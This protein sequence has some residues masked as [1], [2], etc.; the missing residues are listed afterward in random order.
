MAA[1]G[2]ILIKVTGASTGV[3]NINTE[4]AWFSDDN[5]TESFYSLL[6]GDGGWRV[7]RF[8]SSTSFALLVEVGEV[9]KGGNGGWLL[10]GWLVG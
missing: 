1:A 3:I 8:R 10:V 6:G 4:A 2:V 9:R 7:N 5:D